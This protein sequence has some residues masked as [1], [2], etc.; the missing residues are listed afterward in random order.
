MPL[1]YSTTQLLYQGAGMSEEQSQEASLAKCST[2]SHL[3][4]TRLWVRASKKTLPLFRLSHV[5]IDL[6]NVMC[7]LLLVEICESVI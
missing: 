7:L 1:C 5:K 4:G 3:Q 2:K 6:C